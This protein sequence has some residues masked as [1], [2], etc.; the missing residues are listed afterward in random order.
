MLQ[1][2]C[3]CKLIIKDSECFLFLGRRTFSCLKVYIIEYRILQFVQIRNG[4]KFELQSQDIEFLLQIKVLEVD[5]LCFV[6]SIITRLWVLTAFE[7]TFTLLD[8]KARLF[9][10]GVWLIVI[11]DSKTIHSV[12]ISLNLNLYVGTDN[13]NGFI[14]SHA[15]LKIVN[16]VR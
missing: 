7:L 8:T 16:L 9:I 12:S 4:F 15:K 11:I 1:D 6:L 13:V 5:L 3:L 10:K 14:I 2:I